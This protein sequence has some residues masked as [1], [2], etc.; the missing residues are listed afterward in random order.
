MSEE[1]KPDIIPRKEC[2]QHGGHLAND[3]VHLPIAGLK[4]TNAYKPSGK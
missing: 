3:V 2:F 1:Q 4:K